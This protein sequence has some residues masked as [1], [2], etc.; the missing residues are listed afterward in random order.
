MD[1]PR[2][3]YINY[4]RILSISGWG[5]L[6]ISIRQLIRMRIGQIR[7][8]L[9]GDAI[10]T[11]VRNLQPQAVVMGGTRP[12]VRWAGSEQ[13]W[14][15]YPLWN[16]VHQNEWVENWVGPQHLGW[17]V[18]ES[19]IHTRD[20]WFWAPGTDQ[21]LRSVDFLTNVY[22]TSIGQGANLLINMTPDRDGLIPPAEMQRLDDFGK[23]ISKRFSK[24]LAD[25][26]SQNGWTAPGI[27]VLDLKPGSKVNLIVIEENL[28]NGQNILE[29]SIEA[30]L[31]DTWKEIAKGKSI[32]RKRI[33]KVEEIYT[34]KIRLVAQ[35]LLKD[36]DI[37]K[38]V[39]YN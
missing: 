25:T 26:S 14:A 39:V 27:L 2:R 29:Y 34:T 17:I 37:N 11:M 1:R 22:D 10:R 5:C 20:T 28:K 12:D 7:M 13:G 35:K 38:F 23:N 9:Y 4:S 19:N 3:R 16:V 24:P 33:H 36:A 18:P 6:S 32:G 8:L 15:P 30:W 31:D 21:T